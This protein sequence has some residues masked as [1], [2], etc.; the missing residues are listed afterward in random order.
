MC[1]DIKTDF[2][3]QISNPTG[4]CQTSNPKFGAP[5]KSGIKVS[6]EALIHHFKFFSSGFNV[7]SG[8][9]YSAVE[10]PKK[11]FKVYLISDGSLKPFRF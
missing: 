7:D 6:M 5:D 10:A 1:F 9:I 11:E 8:E 4:V 3:V 2:I